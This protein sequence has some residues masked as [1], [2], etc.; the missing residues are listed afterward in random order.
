[1]ND[2]NII[3]IKESPVS[4]DRIYEITIEINKQIYNGLVIKKDEK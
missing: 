1:M 2:I 3:N 4:P